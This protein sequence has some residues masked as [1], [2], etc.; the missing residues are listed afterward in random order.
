MRPIKQDTGDSLLVAARPGQVAHDPK[1]Y[2]T[3][4]SEMGLITA[5]R[6]IWIVAKLYQQAGC[7]QNS[8]RKR[9]KAERKYHG[10]LFDRPLRAYWLLREIIQ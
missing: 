2:L 7:R 3:S 6:P 8:V 10:C 1:N 9:V 5:A 4:G